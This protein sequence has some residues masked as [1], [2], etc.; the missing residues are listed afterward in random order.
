MA[1]PSEKKRRP[2]AET[3]ADRQAR[4][5]LGRSVLAVSIVG[6]AALVFAAIEAYVRFAGDTRALPIN[7]ASATYAGGVVCAGCHAGEAAAWARSHHA[8]AMQ[9]A[10]E[11]TVLGDFDDARFTYDGIT[12]RFFRKDGK[13][14][15]NTDGPDGTMADFAIVYTFGVDPLQQYLIA[16]PDGRLQALSI[17]W[18]ARPREAGGQRWFHLHPDE[19]IRHGDI[20]HWTGI[21]Q[22]WNFMCAECHSTDV[23]KNYDAAENRFHT[24]WSDIS[25]NCEACHG[26]GS[27][28]VAWAQRRQRWWPFGGDDDPRKG[29][30]VAFTE[31]AGVTWS[32]EPTSGQPR[33]SALQPLRIELET[34]GRCHSRRAEISENWLPGRSLSDTHLVALLERGLYRADGQIEDEVYEYGSFRQSKMFAHGV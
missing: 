26:P 2:S 12:S 11:R 16:F 23:R 29:L 24:T 14:V 7:P 27:R 31:R 34:C 33:R 19:A 30:A 5:P 15:V 17:A 22:N 18:D 32:R 28:H 9:E 20:L 3:A 4:R 21:N 25:V 1:V 6:A 13:F 8:R 10:G